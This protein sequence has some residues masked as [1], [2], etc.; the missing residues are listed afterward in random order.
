MQDA[1]AT[2]VITPDTVVSITPEQVASPLVNEMAILNL[3]NE[4]YYTLNPVGARVWELLAA[5]RRV[6]ELRDALI[7]R[8]DVAPERCERE[9]IALLEEMRREGLIEVQD[10][11][12][13]P[14]LE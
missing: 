7:A 9:L 8:Y 1:P 3:K 14:P 4:A 5:P 2:D 13:N 10:S 11:K 12:E 6:D